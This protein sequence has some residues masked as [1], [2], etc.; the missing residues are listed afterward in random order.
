M[1]GGCKARGDVV[2]GSRDEVRGEGESEA[3]RVERGRRTRA[4]YVSREWQH[5]LGVIA[6]YLQ[7]EE[8]E[9]GRGDGEKV[10]EMA[11]AQRGSVVSGG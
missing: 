9:W 3:W 1:G 5:E 2:N 6:R 4:V 11:G 10:E 8:G 7:R